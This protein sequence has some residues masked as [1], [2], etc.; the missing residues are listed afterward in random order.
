[1]YT[2]VCL[3][4]LVDRGSDQHQETAPPP[5]LLMRVVKSIVLHYQAAGRSESYQRSALR[6]KVLQGL[7]RSP[8]PLAV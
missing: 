8:L 2:N 5:L 4:W 3:R 1:M 7:C 6:A